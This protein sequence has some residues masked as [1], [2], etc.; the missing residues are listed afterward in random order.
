MAPRTRLQDRLDLAQDGQGDFF[1]GLGS[2]I[3]P[4]WTEDGPRMERLLVGLQYLYS[5]VLY[6]FGIELLWRLLEGAQ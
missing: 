4:G 3:Q 2:D 6:R 1:G 5:I